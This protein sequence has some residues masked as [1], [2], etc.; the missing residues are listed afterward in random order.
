MIGGIVEIGRI[1]AEVQDRCPDRCAEFLTEKLKWKSRQSGQNFLTVFHM[2]QSPKFGHVDPDDLTIDASS[3][4]LLAAPS[5][6][7]IAGRA[8]WRRTGLVVIGRW[9]ANRAAPVAADTRP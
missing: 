5:T 1:L 7:K 3:L 4:Y 6:P 2:F 8:A 9:A